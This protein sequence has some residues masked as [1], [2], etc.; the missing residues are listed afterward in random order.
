MASMK[1]V[2]EGDGNDPFPKTPSSLDADADE[3]MDAEGDSSLPPEF[4]SA[5]DA[6]QQA[7]SAQT[8]WDAVEACTGNSKPPGGG[9][10]AI[11]GKSKSPKK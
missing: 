1:D 8:F 4:E 5:F 10:L 2:F 9:L 3:D 6:Y 11:L 7:P